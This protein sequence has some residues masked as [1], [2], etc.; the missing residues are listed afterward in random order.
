M[1]FEE[2]Q[3]SPS[4]R[5]PPANIWLRGGSLEVPE[6][7]CTQ[8]I[9]MQEWEEGGTDIRQPRCGR[10]ASSW[11]DLNRHAAPQVVVQVGSKNS[12]AMYLGNFEGRQSAMMMGTISMEDWNYTFLR[13]SSHK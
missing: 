1:S 13:T 3:Q 9:E 5:R 10:H 6:Q 7:A 12:L 8:H 4:Q 11:M 2:N